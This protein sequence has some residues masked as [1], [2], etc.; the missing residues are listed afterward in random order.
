[1]ARKNKKINS[2]S[3]MTPTVSVSKK[4]R[5]ERWITAGLNAI[6]NAAIKPTDLPPMSFPTK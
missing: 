5:E 2:K 3:E 1:M 6:I 4:P